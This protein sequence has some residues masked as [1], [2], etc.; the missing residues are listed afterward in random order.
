MLLFA[1]SERILDY[2]AGYVGVCITKYEGQVKATIAAKLYGTP[3]K[4]NKIAEL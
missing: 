2:G 4:L 1:I 3:V